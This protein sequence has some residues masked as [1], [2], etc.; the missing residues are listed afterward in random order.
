MPATSLEAIAPAVACNG[1]G[2]GRHIDSEK[3]RPAI[4]TRHQTHHHQAFDVVWW[5][6]IARPTPGEI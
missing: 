3:S 4:G 1:T 2:V 5:N 6:Q